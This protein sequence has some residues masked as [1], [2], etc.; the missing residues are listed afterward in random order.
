MRNV[1]NLNALPEQTQRALSR[2]RLAVVDMDGTLLLPGGD[3][4]PGM[5][6]VLGEL[7]DA[8]IT[9]VPVSGR[10]QYTLARMFDP[11][12]PGMTLIG[13]NGGMI[14]R[15]GH[16]EPTV[17]FEPDLVH[18]LID[19]VRQLRA[20]NYDVGLLLS[21]PEGAYVERTD[22]PFLDQVLYYN[23]RTNQIGDLHEAGAS[24]CTK[25]ALYDF[26]HPDTGSYARLA[27][28]KDQLQIVRAADHWLDFMPLG[29]NKG[30]AVRTLQTDLGISHDETIGF[31][32]Y[33]NDNELL[34]AC[35]FSFAMA[36][37]HENVFPH[38][39]YVAEHHAH[40]GVLKVMKWILS[41]RR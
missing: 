32:D 36:N 38:A 5:W 37:A 11:H 17:V 1:T 40:A 27:P 6:D 26:G 2:V 16:G 20:E 33:E 25:M 41:H 35:G 12:H 34:D 30:V 4:P 13:E 8:G 39:R 15:D 22:Q 10:Q 23:V 3:F 31:G 21:T 28:F 14:R 18:A 9:F 19:A 29:S 24:P 7:D